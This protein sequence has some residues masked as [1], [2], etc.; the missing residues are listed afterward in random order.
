M[1]H[2]CKERE[3][4]THC[5]KGISEPTQRIILSSTNESRSFPGNY[6]DETFLFT[7]FALQRVSA[8]TPSAPGMARDPNADSLAL[9]EAP[10][11]FQGVCFSK[12]YRNDFR[13]IATF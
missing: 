3:I 8:M 2:V 10:P 4:S 13:S 7:L 12:L 9:R 6:D 5:D 11:G 1:S